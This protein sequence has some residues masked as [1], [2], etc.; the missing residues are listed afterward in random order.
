MTKPVLSLLLVFFLITSCGQVPSP[1]ATQEQVLAPS[2]TLTELASPSPIPNKDIQVVNPKDSGPGTLRQALQE[3]GAETIITFDPVTFPP[4]HPTTIMLL[5][6][7][8]PIDKGQTT[9]DASEA[10]V[11]L[12]GSQVGGDWAPGIDIA[13]SGN[14]VRGLQITGFNGPGILVRSNAEK[15]IIGGERNIGKGPYGQGNLIHNCAAG[16]ALRGP[17]NLI[18]GNLIG[19]DA[20]GQKRWGNAEAGVFLEEN[21]NRNII[22]PANII[23]FNGTSGSG[24]G[25]DIQSTDITGNR[26]TQN[27]IHDNADPSIYYDFAQGRRPAQ[28]PQPPQLLEFSLMQGDVSGL[29]CSNCTVEFFTTLRSGGEFYEGSVAAAKDGEFLF[30]KD[31]GFQGGQLKATAYSELQ[32][33][34]EFSAYTYSASRAIKLQ[35]YNPNPRLALPIVPFKDSPFNAIGTTQYLSC[36]DEETAASYLFDAERMGYK[37][38]RVSLDWFNWSDVRRTGQYSEFKISACQEK[39][40]DLLYQNGVKI[41]YSLVYWDPQIKVN[42][43]YSR[44]RTDDEVQRYLDY[45]RFIVGHF[46]GKIH[47]YSILNEPNAS[48]G[49][50][51]VHVGDYI[52]LVRQVIPLIRETDPETKIVIGE[53]TPL[54]ESGALNYIQPVLKSDIPRLVDGIAWH[55]GAGNSPEYQPD[56]YRNY[57]RWVKEIV[58]TAQNNGFT[59]QFFSTEL[60][61]RTVKTAQSGAPRWVYSDLTVGKYYARGI[62]VHR[63]KNF[64]VTVGH[65]DYETI[66]YAVRA[67]S[68]LTNLLAGAQPIDIQVK[69]KK[70]AEELRTAAFQL[71]DGSRLVAFWRNVPAKDDDSGVPNTITLLGVKAETLTGMDP[72]YAFQQELVFSQNK[73]GVVIENFLIQEY[74]TF[75]RL[76]VP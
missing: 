70:P 50:G 16:I 39:A 31:G 4:D 11:I 26:I 10:G 8:P 71:P 40:I 44:F 22:G 21:A 12:D 3:A 69:L 6:A 43:G 15:N 52:N 30:E 25:V 9:L 7:L 60:Q 48:E 76:N 38:V 23:A 41:L 29:A 54:N 47:W 46:K 62:V 73:D 72:L 19:S 64:L 36:D 67:I 63:A 49:Q 42:D 61:W 65:Q 37:W 51:A 35:N 5:S 34:S 75:I 57:S 28:L 55:G 1:A 66:P 33:N 13:S 17:D 68:S 32:N 59:G 14:I 24:G 45:V 20:S 2:P 53:F 74:P 58:S 18:L 56:F 27:D